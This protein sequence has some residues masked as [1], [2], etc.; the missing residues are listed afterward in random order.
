[1]IPIAK[2]IIDEN[3]KRRVMEVLDSGMISIGKVVAEFEERFA[4]YTGS[5]HAVAVSSGTTALHMALMASGVKA[6]DK[7]LTTPFSFIA[8]AN[9]ALYM[10]AVPVFCDIENRSFNIDPQKI[11]E[12]LKNDPDIKALL[13]VHL[14]GHPCQMDE[15]MEIVEKHNL[16]LIED[17]AQSHGAYFDKKHTGTFGV[18]GT[19]SFYPTKNMT[20]AEGGMVITDSDEVYDHLKMLREHGA[21]KTYEHV[22]LGFNFRMTNIEAAIGLGQMDKLDSFNKAR[23]ENAAYYS[24]ALKGLPWLEIPEVLDNC[25]HCFHQYSLKVKDRDAFTDHLKENGVGFKVYYPTTIPDQPLFRDM[26]YSGDC[27]PISKE[28]TGKIVSIPVHPAITKEDREKVVQVIKGFRP[29]M[30]AP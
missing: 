25:T 15:I 13:I 18:T 26:G 6:G 5:K 22:M 3:E 20:T 4:Q 27:Y 17:C 7:V 28:M 29:A 12:A 8:T 14:F 19:F 10:G 9:A 30:V 2:P 11:R 21:S 16:I 24:E 1:M 23:A